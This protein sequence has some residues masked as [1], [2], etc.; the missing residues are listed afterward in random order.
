MKEVINYDAIVKCAEYAAIAHDGQFR[1]DKRTPYIVHPA[2]VAMLVSLSKIASPISICAAWLHDI[3]EDCC[4]DSIGNKVFNHNES[5]RS[6]L[7]SNVSID[8]ADNI[9]N[10]VID[11]TKNLDPSISKD[12]LNQNAY[13]HIKKVG[14]EESVVIKFCDRI[15]NLST[16][17]CFS[18]SGREWYLR[19]T[20][21]L[22]KILGN[23]CKLIDSEI[24]EML[25]QMLQQKCK[26]YYIEYKVE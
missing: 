4:L 21:K 12:K 14:K 6:Y 25:E 13:E 24:F 3:I 8:I 7:M 23:K 5:L 17:N 16:I 15:D 20:L 26:K 9:I 1:K 22:M 18:A 10:T 19:D 11:L 2:K